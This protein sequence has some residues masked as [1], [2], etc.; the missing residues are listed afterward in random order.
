MLPSAI[1]FRLIFRHRHRRVQQEVG[2]TRLQ[3][4]RIE[5][6]PADVDLV[7]DGLVSER[8]RRWNS[9]PESVS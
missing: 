8:S 9:E 1:S 6:V 2:H 7:E 3:L 4:G 5:L